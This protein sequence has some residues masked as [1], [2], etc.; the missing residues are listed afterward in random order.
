[1]SGFTA[2]RDLPRERADHEQHEPP[3]SAEPFH[4]EDTV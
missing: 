2:E 4:L 1:L 3:Q